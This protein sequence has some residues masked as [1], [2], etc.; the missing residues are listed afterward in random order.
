MRFGLDALLGLVPGLGDTLTSLAS[1]Y[2]LQAAQRHGVS[3]VTLARMGA[4]IAVDY[5][6]GIVPVLGDMFD[7]SWKA[8]QRNVELLRGHLA[9][10]PAEQGRA[11]KQ[12]WWFFAGLVLILLTLLVGSITIAWFVISGIVS[13][14]N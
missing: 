6:V 5:V 1:L 13:L 11:R 12:D 9:A 14:F 2:I 7:V 10:N 8:N 4:N 3:R